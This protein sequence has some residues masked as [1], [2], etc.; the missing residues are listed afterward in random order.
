MDVLTAIEDRRS[1]RLFQPKDVPEEVLKEL[2][3]LLR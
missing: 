2:I 1:I 3:R